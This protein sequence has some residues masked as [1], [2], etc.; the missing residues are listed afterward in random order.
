MK[1]DKWAQFEQSG[2]IFDYLAYKEQAEEMM[3]A[4]DSLKAVV[5]NTEPNL[6]DEYPEQLG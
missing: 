3:F 6:V 5:K 4:D 1:N 2:D